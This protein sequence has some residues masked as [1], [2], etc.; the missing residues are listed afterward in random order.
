[1]RLDYRTSALPPTCGWLRVFGLKVAE[2][3]FR[4]CSLSGKRLARVLN[5]RVTKT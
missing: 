1:M 5:K 3:K 2:F 4:H